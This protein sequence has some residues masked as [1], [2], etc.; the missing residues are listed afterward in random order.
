MRQQWVY[1]TQTYDILCSLDKSQSDSFLVGYP[2]S[3][4]PIRFISSLWSIYDEEIYLHINPLVSYT[5]GTEALYSE[6]VSQSDSHS[7]IL[8]QSATHFALW[9]QMSSYWAVVNQSSSRPPVV[10]QSASRS[11]VVPQ[12][13]SNSV[14]IGQSVPHSPVVGQ[15]TG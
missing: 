12:S 8:G 3:S 9:D 6:Y 10:G 4:G 5:L 1:V 7:A 2:Y 15:S 11:I 14:A 13:A